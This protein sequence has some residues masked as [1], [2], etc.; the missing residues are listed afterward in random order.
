MSLG[1]AG[2]GLSL[3][4]ATPA[5]G[6]ALTGGTPTLL[7]WTPPA[8]GKQHRVKIFASMHVTVATTGGEVDVDFNLPDGTGTSEQIYTASQGTGAPWPNEVSR[9]VQ[10]GTPVTVVQS[11]ALTAGAALVWVEVWGS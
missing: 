8:D 5:A 7:T 1:G 9:V 6:F 10:G 2:G 11:S 4:A 3:Q